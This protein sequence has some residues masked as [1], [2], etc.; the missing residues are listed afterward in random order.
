MQD[1]LKEA[2]DYVL[3]EYRSSGYSFWR[4]LIGKDPLV[5][6]HPKNAGVEIEV[7]SMWDRVKPGGAIRVIV[8]TFELR[9][10]RFR[11]RVPTASFLVYEDDRIETFARDPT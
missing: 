1:L 4:E 8:S 7:S 3:K 2:F 6:T 10:E 5:L 11:V 9:P